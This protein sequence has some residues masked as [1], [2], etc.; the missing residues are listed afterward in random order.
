MDFDK[1]RD[2][3]AA[4]L[5]DAVSEQEASVVS[6]WVVM[7]ELIDDEGPG[8]VKVS[9]DGTPSWVAIGML[10]AG[11]SLYQGQAYADFQEE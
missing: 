7:V 5:A 6:R 11:L 9:S 1:I 4:A 8:L 3:V 2:K 10:S